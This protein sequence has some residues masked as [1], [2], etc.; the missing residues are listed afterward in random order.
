MIPS[1]NYINYNSIEKI[2]SSFGKRNCESFKMM[3]LITHVQDIAIDFH[4]MSYYGNRENQY[5]KIKTKNETLERYSFYTWDITERSEGKNWCCLHKL[6][7]QRIFTPHKILIWND[8]NNVGK[9][10]PYK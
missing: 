10:G 4:S 9:I 8:W 6:V 2:H 1:F 3:D 7:K 5:I